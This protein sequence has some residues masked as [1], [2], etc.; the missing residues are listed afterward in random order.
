[1][2]QKPQSYL[3]DIAPP[4]QWEEHTFLIGPCPKCQRQ[5]LTARDLAGEDLIDICMHCESPIAADKLSWAEPLEVVE[6][7]YF[8]DGFQGQGCDSEGGCRDGACGVQQP[9]EADL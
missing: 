8:I 4:V 9:E 6:L 5:V 2:Q 1:M 7:G 3:A